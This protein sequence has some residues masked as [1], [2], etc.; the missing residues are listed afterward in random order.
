MIAALCLFAMAQGPLEPASAVRV[1][2]S[3]SELVVTLGVDVALRF[4]R[5]P[6]SLRDVT[7]GSCKL[8]ATRRAPDYRLNGAPPRTSLVASRVD[9]RRVELDLSVGEGALESST[10]EELQR[11]ALRGGVGYVRTVRWT[12]PKGTFDPLEEPAFAV[13][14]PRFL[15]AARWVTEIGAYGSSTVSDPGISYTLQHTM[16]AGGDR[17]WFFGMGI[18]EMFQSTNGH[19][20]V[21]QTDVVVVAHPDAALAPIDFVL[22]FVHHPYDRRDFV[23]AHSKEMYRELYETPVV[24]HLD[25][26]RTDAGGAGTE[27][28]RWPSYERCI[29]ARLIW[30]MA[31]GSKLILYSG[32]HGRIEYLP[33]GVTWEAAPGAR[34]VFKGVELSGAGS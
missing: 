23:R 33:K 30:V 28:D 18:A 17:V 13:E 15:P 9:G 5:A 16:T 22:Q 26:A 21:E 32:E 4:S 1:T 8:E 29:E 3:P 20:P 27:G 24:R 7:L 34:P 10:H 12:R 25:P 14:S 11:V 6:F 19:I 31:P 2:E